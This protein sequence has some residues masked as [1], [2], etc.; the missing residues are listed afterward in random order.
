MRFQ[1]EVSGGGFRKKFQGF[2]GF[3]F[4]KFKLGEVPGWRRF[5]VVRG[6]G[7]EEVPG[8]KR[9]QEEV[10][11]GGFRKRSGHTS[12]LSPLTA[13]RSPLTDSLGSNPIL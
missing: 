13:H 9:F 5:R 1:E 7:F 2:Q 10:S 11:V 4:Q 3:G 8:W 12:H 6:F